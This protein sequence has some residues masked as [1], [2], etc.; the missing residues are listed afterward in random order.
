MKPKLLLARISAKPRLA[1]LAAAACLVVITVFNWAARP[2]HA[3]PS[4]PSWTPSFG[5]VGIAPGQTARLNVFPQGPPEFPQGAPSMVTLS[6]IASNG[7]QLPDPTSGQ[8]AQTS[9]SL[10][11][12]QAASLDLAFP[13]GPPSFPGSPFASASRVELRAVVQVEG[14]EGGLANDFAADLEIFDTSTG[15]TTVVLF[16]HNP[17]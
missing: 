3:L 17:D 7:S 16:P 6:F 4:G 11:P 1:A 13:T 14:A 9:L 10:S 8:P 15:R 12:G 5:M 2:V